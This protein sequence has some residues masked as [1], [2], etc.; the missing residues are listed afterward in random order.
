[1]RPRSSRTSS[2]PSPV[3][4]EECLERLLAAL[5]TALQTAEGMVREAKMAVPA[6]QVE[7]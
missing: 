2:S 1:M 5:R 4:G 6:I 3:R 7:E